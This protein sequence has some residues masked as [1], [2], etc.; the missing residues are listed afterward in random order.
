MYQKQPL[1]NAAAVLVLG[2][3]SIVFSCLV[4]GMILGIIGISMY[5]KSK[6]MYNENPDQYEGYGLLVGG[7]VTSIIGTVIGALYTIYWLLIVI[8]IAASV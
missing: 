2:I 6:R 8:G 4:I 3:C 1:P 5:G 7:F